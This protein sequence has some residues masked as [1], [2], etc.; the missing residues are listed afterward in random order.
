M[1]VWVRKIENKETINNTEDPHHEVNLD[2]G[3]E[4]RTII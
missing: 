4:S 1:S 2:P 3:P